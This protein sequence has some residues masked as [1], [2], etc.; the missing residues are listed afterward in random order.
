MKM[1]QFL[2]IA[3][4]LCVFINNIYAQSFERKVVEVPKA[5]PGAIVIDGKM[6]EAA[7]AAAATADM[8]TD[9]GFEIWTNKYYRESLLEP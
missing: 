8:I 4:L 2:V 7:W 6:D 9:T 5:A 1:K 3:G